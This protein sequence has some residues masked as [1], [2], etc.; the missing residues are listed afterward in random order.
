MVFVIFYSMYGHVAKLAS[1]IRSSV[2]QTGCDCRLFQIAET[3]NDEILGKMRALPKSRDI[4][5]IRP[6]QLLEADGYLFGMPTRFGSIPTQVKNFFD[7]CG[8]HWISD[9][10]IGKPVSVISQ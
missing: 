1:Q 9:A 5:F 4:P 6:E 2:E 7:A 8:G 3:L 10:L